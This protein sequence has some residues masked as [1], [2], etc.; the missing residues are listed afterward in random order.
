M[1]CR[2]MDWVSFG[3]LVDAED[4]QR[5]TDAIRAQRIR[6]IVVQQWAVAMAIWMPEYL[7]SFAMARSLFNQRNPKEAANMAERMASEWIASHRNPQS[8]LALILANHPCAVDV[9]DGVE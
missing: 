4:Q 2:C 8:A 5:C 6:D 7:H 1:K 9:V 3:D